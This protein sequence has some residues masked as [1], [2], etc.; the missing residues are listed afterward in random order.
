MKD[1]K[2]R[3]T[4]NWSNRCFKN[5]GSDSDISDLSENREESR[6]AL[7]RR[8]EF[9][10]WPE[11][12]LV[13]HHSKQPS[14]DRW[15]PPGFWCSWWQESLWLQCQG[16][17]GA[18]DIY[19]DYVVQ[20]GDPRKYHS[21]NHCDP[22]QYDFRKLMKLFWVSKFTSCFEDLCTE[23]PMNNSAFFILFFGF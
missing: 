20:I 9:M 16:A 4:W 23:K 8:D 5:S 2:I 3:R 22:F 6:L 19:F 18:A 7:R 15:K 10:Y 14:G 11:P 13:V 21:S 17:S 12:F 1:K